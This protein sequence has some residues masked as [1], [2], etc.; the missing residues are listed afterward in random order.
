MR[1]GSSI[2]TASKA[3]DG[4]CFPVGVLGARSVNGDYSTGL[5]KQHVKWHLCSA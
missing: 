4:S 2:G 1:L 5:C 3:L